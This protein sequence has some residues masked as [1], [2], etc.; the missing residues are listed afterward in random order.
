MKLKYLRIFIIEHNRGISFI[1]GGLNLFCMETNGDHVIRVSRT[2]DYPVLMWNNIKSELITKTD[3]NKIIVMR[4][5]Q[6]HYEIMY[7]NE[8]YMLLLYCGM[9]GYAYC[10]EE[11]RLIEQPLFK[12]IIPSMQN[13][14]NYFS[15]QFKHG[16]SILN[17]KVM[18]Y[19]NGK[20]ISK[21][22]LKK[23]LI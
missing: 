23:W 5:Y 18:F 4:V 10:I 14:S 12:G 15:R 8:N 22:N 17:G 20:S 19:K 21:R 13:Y 6:N 1:L 3:N 11:H 2:F 16:Y 9:D 7:V